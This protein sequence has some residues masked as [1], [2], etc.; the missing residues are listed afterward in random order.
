VKVESC[1]YKRTRVAENCGYC[2]NWNPR[3]YQRGTENHVGASH[4][5]S[6]RR[7][8]TDQNTA[9]ER[10]WPRRPCSR[11]SCPSKRSQRVVSAAANARTH[12]PERSSS[13]VCI[14]AHL[15]SLREF[16][17]WCDLFP[18]GTA[19]PQLERFAA[20]Q[21][22]EQRTVCPAVRRAPNIASTTTRR[23][24]ETRLE[25]PRRFHGHC[26]AARIEFF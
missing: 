17:P 26:H 11:G 1:R 18:A 20:T 13:D 24:P 16:N 25:H 12:V 22:L 10:N 21:P 5:P 6:P 4:R 7:R 15:L 2:S 19:G 3:R 14:D 9:Y 8:R 23:Y